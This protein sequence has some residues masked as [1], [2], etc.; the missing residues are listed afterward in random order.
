MGAGQISGLAEPGRFFPRQIFARPLEPSHSPSFPI[1]LPRVRTL[2]CFRAFLLSSP[3]LSL[4]PPS[5]M[6]GGLFGKAPTPEE[7]VKQ[8]RSQLRNETRQLDRQIRDIERQELKAKQ[9]LKEFSKKGQIDSCRSLAKELVMSKNAKNRIIQSKAHLNSVSMQLTQQLSFIKVSGSLAQSA[10]IMQAMNSLM[11]VP[12]LSMTMR[13][14]S[15]E[16]AKAGIIEEMMD[17][18]MESLDAD[19]DFDEEVSTEVE[20]ILHEVSLGVTGKMARAPVGGLPVQQSEE[21]AVSDSDLEARLRS[22]Q[23]T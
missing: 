14:M 1:P 23:Q 19:P 4:F 8:W 20:K 15:K 5:I 18:A 6:F 16:M 9:T 3:H 13:S 22:L 17:D 10:E 2:F 7:R 12:E 21:T 11:R